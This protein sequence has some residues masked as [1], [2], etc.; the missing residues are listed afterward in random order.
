MKNLK[1]KVSKFSEDTLIINYKW[2]KREKFKVRSI[3]NKLSK[4]RINMIAK[5]I[6][7]QFYDLLPL[8][9]DN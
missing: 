5:L 3:I 8:E 2:N 7:E 4:K 1:M 6:W 9:M